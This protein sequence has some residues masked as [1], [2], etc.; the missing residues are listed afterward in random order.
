[1]VQVFAILG[2]M[3]EITGKTNSFLL[4]L[5]TFI[6]G[7]YSW[8]TGIKCKGIS[9]VGQGQMVRCWLPARDEIT[10]AHLCKSHLIPPSQISC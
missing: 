5:E 9:D 3:V 6:K 1:M 10:N 2:K 4:P 8:T 7:V